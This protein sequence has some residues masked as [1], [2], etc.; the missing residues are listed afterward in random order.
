[1][2][3]YIQ[4]GIDKG[5]ISLKIGRESNTYVKRRNVTVFSIQSAS[6]RQLNRKLSG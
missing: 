1:M 4:I 2:K 3:D 6:L 5:H